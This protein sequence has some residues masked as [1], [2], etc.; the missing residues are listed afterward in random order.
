MTRTNYVTLHDII[1][2]SHSFPLSSKYSSQRPLLRTPPPFQIPNLFRSL[3]AVA[4]TL[5]LH[6]PT[7]F[8]E[9]F[10]HFSRSVEANDG[11][12]L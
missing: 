11:T 2:S 12:A 10:C 6:A 7:T 3:R 8:S 4:L 1:F 9:D 5:R